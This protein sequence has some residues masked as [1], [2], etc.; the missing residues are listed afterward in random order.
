MGMEVIVVV[1]HFLFFVYLVTT[2]SVRSTTH[3]LTIYYIEPYLIEIGD[4]VNTILGLMI[5]AGILAA[6]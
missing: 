2:D 4:N 6:T 5:A 3:S 1:N